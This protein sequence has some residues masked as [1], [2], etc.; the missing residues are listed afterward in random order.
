LFHHVHFKKAATLTLINVTSRSLKDLDTLYSSNTNGIFKNKIDD[1]GFCDVLP[2]S[3]VRIYHCFGQ[4]FCPN[5]S[6]R[7]R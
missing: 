6:S 3:Y 4:T 1:Y 5:F 2:C 7:D